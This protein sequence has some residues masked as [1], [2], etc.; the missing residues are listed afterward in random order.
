VDR[1]RAYYSLGQLTYH[2]AMPAP[3][4][5]RVLDRSVHIELSSVDEVDRWAE[6]L[7]MPKPW[8]VTS[9]SYGTV[10]FYA[11]AES[12]WLGA[13]VVSVS[14]ENLKNEEMRSGEQREIVAS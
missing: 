3:Q 9:T 13:T 7:E 14:C 10:E 11:D 12:N 1:S 5:I 8:H 6:R 2:G 4:L